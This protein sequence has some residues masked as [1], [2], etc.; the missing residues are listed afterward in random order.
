MRAENTPWH[1]VTGYG[2]HIK[3][4]ANDL[5]IVQGGD[6][7]HHPLAGVRHLLVVGGH[8][9][10]TSAVINLLKG[11]SA[12]SF[13]DIDGTPV[14]FLYPYGYRAHEEV[15]NAQYQAAPHRYATAVAVSALR[16]RLLFVERA[17]EEMDRDVLYEG[18][19]V[20]L[21]QMR[22]ELQE[23]ITMDELRRLHRLSS[24]MYY[25]ILARLIPPGFGYRRRT[26][27]PH[28]DPINAM[29]SLGY[30]ILYG[31]CCVAIVGA[32]LD[33][34]CGFLQEGEGGLVHDLIEPL[35]AEM[36]DGAVVALALEG[37]PAG[38]YELS[39][40]R[41]YL[42]EDLTNHLIGALRASIDQKRVDAQV[43]LLQEA[44]VQ[45]REFQMLY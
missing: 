38:E 4:T 31:A 26:S 25:E 37:I 20:L 5:I 2:G 34:D 7:R 23:L 21:H 8:T 30:A 11:G 36:V 41:C 45:N 17:C 9:L 15:Q 3:A 39:A 35:K 14:G 18:E 42:S 22:D 33:P 1:A 16:S 19:L 29:L 10:H 44:L 13:F 40:A 27:R 6:T 28:Q 43:V 12:I 24:D 32:H